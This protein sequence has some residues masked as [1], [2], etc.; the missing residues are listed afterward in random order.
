MEK[1]NKDKEKEKKKEER[2]DFK[3]LWTGQGGLALVFHNLLVYWD[4]H[5]QQAEK[6]KYPMS[7]S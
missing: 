3:L 2:E 5:R 7:G 1:Q 6:S 4:S